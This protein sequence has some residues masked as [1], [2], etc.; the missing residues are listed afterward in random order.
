MDYYTVLGVDK[1]ASKDNIKKAYRKLAMKHHPDRNGGDETEFKK[2]QE[3]YDVLGDDAKKQ[4]H[5]N[6]R[7]KFED[8]FGRGGNPFDDIFRQAGARRQ[9]HKN[10]DGMMHV[11]VSL[12]DA[13]TGGEFP[14]N[15]QSGQVKLN[16]PAGVR[17]GTKFKIPGHG[18]QR[19]AEFPPGDLYVTVMTQQD[20]TWW[21]SADDLF[22]K[23]TINAIEAMTGISKSIEHIS[24]KKYKVEIPAGVQPANNVR[25]KGLGMPNPNNNT[26]GNLNVMIEVT[27]PTITDKDDIEILNKL[28]GKLDGQ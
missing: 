26:V 2:I 17:D 19:W 15:L 12:K 6:P 22:I 4:A 24:G 28:R 23:V 3:A 25:L 10:P 20:D 9:V 8:V 14:L 1:N 5:D 11:E 21:R 16:I 18:P 13:F 7:P 27:V